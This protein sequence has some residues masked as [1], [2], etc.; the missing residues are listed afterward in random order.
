LCASRSQNCQLVLTRDLSQSFTGRTVRLEAALGAQDAEQLLERLAGFQL[1]ESVRT[2]LLALVHGHPLALT[3]A[4][5][6]LARGDEE[7]HYL[8]ETWSNE[9]LPS[10]SRRAGGPRSGPLNASY[11]R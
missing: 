8:V 7:P 1:A 4:A 11:P 9:E 6:L 10:L 2:Q 5:G 3:W